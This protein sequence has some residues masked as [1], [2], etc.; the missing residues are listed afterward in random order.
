MWV[1]QELLYYVRSRP[2]FNIEA[3]YTQIPKA[4]KGYYK[5]VGGRLTRNTDRGRSATIRAGN[6]WIDV[7]QVFYRL[8][9]NVPGCY[10]QKPLKAVERLLRAGSSPGDTVLDPFAHSGTT[11]LAAE[12]QGR[13]A[14][15]FDVDPVFVEIAIRRLERWRSTGQ[16]GW[17]CEHPFPEDRAPA[18]RP[19]SRPTARRSS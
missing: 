7:Q 10:A 9:E 19:P 1:R 12:R 2:I 4:V 8:H 13:R 18:T 3:E 14:I 5:E 15:T 6:V 16:T 17:Q 11:L